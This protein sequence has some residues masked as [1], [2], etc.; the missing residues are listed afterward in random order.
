MNSKRRLQIG[1][2]SFC[3]TEAAKHEHAAY[4]L[5]YDVDYH[6]H[7]AEMF[8]RLASKAVR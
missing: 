6:A 2:K 3:L 4:T 7:M 5:N 8:Y 1:T